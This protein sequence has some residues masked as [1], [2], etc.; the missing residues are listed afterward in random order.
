MN[1][2]YDA[3]IVGAGP[4]GATAAILLADAGWSVA[5]VEKQRFPRR[6]VCGECIAAPNIEL[7]HALGLGDRFDQLAGAALR[8]VA[9]FCGRQQVYADLPPFG[10]GPQRWGRALGR[11]YLDQMLLQR[12]ESAGAI[13][14]QPYSASSMDGEAGRYTCEIVHADNASTAILA[15]PI[16]IAA[17]G[18]WQVAPYARQA[19]SPK[20]AGDL[21]GFK[22]NYLNAR[23]PAGTLPVLSFAGGYGGMVVGD[24]ATTTLACCIRRDLLAQCRRRYGT[25]TAAQ[26]VE[27][28]L[29]DSCRG[30]AEA[31]AGAELQGDWL[32][33]GPIRPGIRVQGGATNQPFLVGN[34]AGE[35]HPIIGEGISMAMQSAWLLCQRLIAHK[36]DTLHIEGYRNLQTS[37]ARDWQRSFAPR[38]RLAALFAH[39]AMRPLATGGL[40]PLL[41]RWPVL[42]THGA[43]FSGKASSVG[44]ILNASRISLATTAAVDY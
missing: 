42:L 1:S 6:K 3:I 5:I 18:S 39:I 12:A 25:H 8:R 21:F 11:E 20:K 13:V 31:I 36:R 37:Y 38:I 29:Q 17:H 44:L 22:A 26:A 40:M 10:N 35:S 19:R 7:L 2:E 4:A 33:V 30:V 14:L 9:L 41:Q 27:A 43:R 24:H 34:A 23:L 32:S 16:M 15:A 28:Y